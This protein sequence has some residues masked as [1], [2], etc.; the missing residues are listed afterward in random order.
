MFLL[1]ED[2]ED[3]ESFKFPSEGGWMYCTGIDTLGFVID[4]LS[5][6]GNK[7]LYIEGVSEPNIKSYYIRHRINNSPDKIFV[8][9]W[10]MID[11]GHAGSGIFV[12]GGTAFSYYAGV[13]YGNHDHYFSTLGTHNGTWEDKPDYYHGGIMRWNKLAFE[14]DRENKTQKVYINDYLVYEDSCTTCSFGKI[15]NVFL[16]ASQ[17]GAFI[18]DVKVWYYEND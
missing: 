15:E 14:F 2:F 10:I 6:S 18:D 11:H 12:G 8:E 17:T 16:F 9:A 1:N 4:T 7:S 5:R 13:S 3:Y